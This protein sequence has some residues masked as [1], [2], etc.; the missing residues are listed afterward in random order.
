M[1]EKTIG[2]AEADL[3]LLGR[4]S[5]YLTFKRGLLY[6]H[7]PAITDLKIIGKVMYETDGSLVM[8]VA[9]KQE[10]SPP[11]G[12]KKLNMNLNKGMVSMQA[13]EDA[14]YQYLLIGTQSLYMLQDCYS[15]TA[16]NFLQCL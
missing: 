14:V 12:F 15:Q 16:I 4:I 2:G 10:Q 7:T 9:P 6:G 13:V 5:T 8:P 1:L 3:N 11:P